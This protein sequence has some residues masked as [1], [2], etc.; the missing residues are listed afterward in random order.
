MSCV[1]F[2][3]MDSFGSNEN[4]A[5]S[6]DTKWLVWSTAV[7]IA[8]WTVLWL[9]ARRQ[10]WWLWAIRGLLSPIVGSFLF[11]PATQWAFAVIF[12]YY[13]IVFPIGLVTGLL[14][15]LIS[16]FYRPSVQATP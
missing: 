4:F 12:E 9:S 14:V 10:S 5:D 15:A 1:G 13:R 3:L 7:S 16:V 8:T 6:H 11:F 2:H